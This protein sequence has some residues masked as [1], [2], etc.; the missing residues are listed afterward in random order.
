MVTASRSS[1][2]ALLVHH[3]FYALSRSEPVRPAH[4]PDSGH[5][6]QQLSK[7]LNEE[8]FQDECKSPPSPPLAIVYDHARLP[9]P[10]STDLI[11]I[12]DDIVDNVRLRVSLIP[13]L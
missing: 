9:F 8:D 12:D 6:N 13:A 5:S 10:L 11:T 1:V 7:D 4:P 3:S 2:R